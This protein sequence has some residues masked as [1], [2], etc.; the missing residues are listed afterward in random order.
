MCG[1][2]DPLGVHTSRSRSRDV[3]IQDRSR[4]NTAGRG[5]NE[6]ISSG[7]KYLS[8]FLKYEVKNRRAKARKKQKHN[9]CCLLLLC[10]FSKTHFDKSISVSR[11]NNT[12]CGGL[13]AEFPANGGSRAKLPRAA[14]ILQTFF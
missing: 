2:F 8:Q 6:K 1:R 4:P 3:C 9:I 12:P 10:Y 11:S 7:A 14:A 13:R 5:E